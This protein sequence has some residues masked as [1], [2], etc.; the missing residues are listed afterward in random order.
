VG[1]QHYDEAIAQHIAINSAVR[2]PSKKDGCR[3][4]R[5][6]SDASDRPMI[7]SFEVGSN[8]GWGL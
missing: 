6:P 5:G 3:G 4:W 2:T 7:M 1:S 8:S